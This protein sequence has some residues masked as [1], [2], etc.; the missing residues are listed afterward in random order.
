MAHR[1]WVFT[2]NNFVEEDEEA[3][4]ALSRDPNLIHR[5]AVGREVAP[6]TGTRHLQGAVVFA[7]PKRLTAAKALL[8]TQGHWERMA[9]T[10]DQ[11]RTYAIK[12][13]DLV[14]DQTNVAQGR[15][16][17]R[18]TAYEAAR[19]GMGIMDYL[20][21]YEPGMP[22]IELFRTVTLLMDRSP[23]WRDVNVVSIYG[24]PGSGKS[25]A[26]HAQRCADG[27]RVWVVPKGA[28]GIRWDTYSKEDTILFDDYRPDYCKFNELLRI[29][30]GH[31]LE[32]DC[33]Y[34]NKNAHWTRV[35]FTSV[36]PL[37]DM[38]RGR[39]DED[40]EQLQ[41]RVTRTVTVTE[42]RGNTIPGLRYHLGT[43]TP[44]A[45]ASAEPAAAGGAGAP[46]EE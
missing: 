29:L 12:D 34:Q 18:V 28:S 42:V 39:I 44:P 6:T 13:H 16:T 33:R 36:I 15:R 24:P 17:D 8:P 43:G 3:L 10:W 2:I 30:D 40:L 35:I 21:Q 27:R 41:R 22:G 37:M 20:T 5:I 32:L 1:S 23:D 45:Q 7:Q 11:A 25:R 14:V 38:W 4:V 9:G 19:A 31:P 26:A 46:P